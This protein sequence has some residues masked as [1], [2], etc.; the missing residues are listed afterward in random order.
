[1]DRPLVSPE[2]FPPPL[3]LL[4]HTAQREIDGH[5]NENGLCAICGSAFPCERA[6]LADLALGGL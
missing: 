2:F 5:V 6:S 3:V 1:M 4:L